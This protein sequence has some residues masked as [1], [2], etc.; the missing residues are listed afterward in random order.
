MRGDT[1]ADA[2]DIKGIRKFGEKLYANKIDDLDSIRILQ[3][4]SLKYSDPQ[5]FLNLL[6]SLYPSALSTG[7]NYHLI[8][9]M[10]LLAKLTDS[11]CPSLFFSIYNSQDDF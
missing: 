8:S 7:L 9:C 4:L 1:T 10:K 5:I 2:V 11:F 6:M 3:S